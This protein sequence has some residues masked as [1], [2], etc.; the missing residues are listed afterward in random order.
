MGEAIYYLKVRFKDTEEAKKALPL[1]KDFFVEGIKAENFWQKHRHGKPENFWRVFQKRF[2]LVYEYLDSTK[3][4]NKNDCNNSLAGCLDFMNCSNKV[5]ENKVESYVLIHGTSILYSA[6]V[7][8][9][10]DWD[11]MCSFIE[12]KFGATASDWVSSDEMAEGSARNPF[13]TI[14]V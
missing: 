11:P 2:P 3:L 9:L 10:A 14:H 6:E 7:W 12:K 5:A 8:H 1:I 4:L 13:D